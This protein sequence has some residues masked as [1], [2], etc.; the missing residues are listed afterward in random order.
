MR[1]ES[2]KYI[3]FMRAEKNRVKLQY[4]KVSTAGIIHHYIQKKSDHTFFGVGGS[5]VSMAHQKPL[6]HSSHT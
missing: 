6:E 4:E 1:R 3:I 2:L 5:S